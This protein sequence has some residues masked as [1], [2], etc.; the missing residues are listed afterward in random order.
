MKVHVNPDKEV[1]EMIRQGLKE[2]DGYWLYASSKKSELDSVICE[3]LIA[4]LKN[5][6]LLFLFGSNAI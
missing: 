4:L 6:L 2:N 3:Y 5:V 1:T